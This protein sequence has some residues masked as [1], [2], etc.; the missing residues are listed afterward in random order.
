MYH[1]PFVGILNNHSSKCFAICTLV[2]N[3][4][5]HLLG[6]YILICI[7]MVEDIFIYNER[8]QYLGKYTLHAARPST[9][10]VTAFFIRVPPLENIRLYETG[11]SILFLRRLNSLMYIYIN[12][13]MKLL[14]KYSFLCSYDV[15]T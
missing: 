12:K 8:A 7:T 14:G 15:H 5:D 4:S 10:C 9:S 2:R 13:S 3:I 11:R 6:K 1:Y